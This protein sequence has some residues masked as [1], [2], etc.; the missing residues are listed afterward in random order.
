M[1]T[2]FLDLALILAAFLA[3]GRFV[4]RGAPRRAGVLYLT[5]LG[6]ALALCAASAWGLDG[7]LSAGVP[8]FFKGVFFS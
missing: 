2:L 7:A 5:L 4:L 3:E 6:L 1:S 8:E